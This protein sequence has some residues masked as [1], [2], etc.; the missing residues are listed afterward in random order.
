MPNAVVYTGVG[1]TFKFRIEPLAART[2]WHKADNYSILYTMNRDEEE[3]EDREEHPKEED[4]ATSERLLK[5]R[6][7]VLSGEVDKPLAARVV[8]QLLILEN[9]SDDPIKLYI[10]SP[11][12]DVDAAFAIFDTTRFIK[13][14]VLTIGMGLVAS[15][16]ALILLAA[17][18]ENRYGFPNS[19]YLL[20]QPLS[21]IRG[22]ATDIEI[23]AREVERTRARINRI[24]SVECSKSIAQIEKDTDRDFWLNAEE[25]LKYSLIGRVV[26]S[27]TQIGS[28]PSGSSA[29]KKG[30]PRKSAKK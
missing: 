8:H 4:S 20:H 27:S 13:P 6:T 10:D 26:T 5:L 18:K 15:A 14:A 19:H 25:A 29:A 3:H 30:A 9:E 22:V 7:V 24:V 12:G 28:T 11:G 17:K 23:H 2:L 1:L 21:G 16:G